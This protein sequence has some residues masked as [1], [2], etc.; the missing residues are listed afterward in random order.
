MGDIYIKGKLKYIAKD[1]AFD[2]E[3]NFG[4]KIDFNE[5]G[6]LT[7]DTLELFVNSKSKI[8]YFPRGYLPINSFIE[9]SLPQ[10]ETSCGILYIDSDKEFIP[11]I[12][13]NYALCNNWRRYYDKETGWMYFGSIDIDLNSV[14]IEYANNTVMSL[15]KRKLLALWFRPLII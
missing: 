9:Y 1:Y 11:S 15:S 7:F 14:N 12:A 4:N 6:S 13:I 10:I 5:L 2:Y 8:V 3:T